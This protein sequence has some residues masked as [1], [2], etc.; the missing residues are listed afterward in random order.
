MRRAQAWEA[1]PETEAADTFVDDGATR[2]IL[3]CRRG[4]ETEV[5]ELRDGDVATFGRAEGVTVRIDTPKV[6]RKHA[7][8]S[9]K[10][11]VLFV[12]DLGSRNGTSVNGQVLKKAGCTVA[13]GGLVRI[14]GCEI[15]I[16][17]A[18]G[19]APS[20]LEDAQP[21]QDDMLV[22]DPQMDQV[23][24]TARKVARTTTTVLIVGETGVGKEVMAQHIHSMSPRRDKPLVAVNCAAIAETLLESEL[25]GHKKGAFTGADRRKIGYVESA[26][27]GTLFIDEIGELSAQAQVKLLRVL[28]SRVVARVGGTAEVPVDVRIICATHRDLPAMVEHGEFRADLYYRISSFMLQIP[29][30]R[31][32]RAEIA[33]LARLFLRS[34]AQATGDTAPSITPAAITAFERHEWPG[35]VRELRNAIEHAMVMSEG[36]P[37][38][39]EHLPA[40]ILRPNT[41]KVGQTEASGMRDKLAQIERKSI[42]DAL[43]AENG[44]Q[45]RAAQRLGISRRG[46]VYKLSRYRRG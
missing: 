32:R 7:T 12:E 42:E 39:A 18:A 33:V 15:V 25:F 6:S 22:A 1:D 3:V 27:G 40:E 35:N 30:L 26:Q 29:P 2:A 37:I 45:T 36:G 11:G 5:I 4:D 20:S 46:L 31:E 13:G 17:T 34:F 16:A 19:P 9:F 28:E 43:V 24:A 23:M 10:G 14:A 21:S 41:K 44:N 8:I 38:G